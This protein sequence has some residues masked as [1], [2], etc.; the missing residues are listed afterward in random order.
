MQPPQ[1]SPSLPRGGGPAGEAGWWRGKRAVASVTIQR[2]TAS[3]SSRR[4][5]AGIRR[6]SIPA[7]R[8]HLS[9]ASSRCG[10]FPY[11]CASPSTSMAKRA[12]LQK[13]RPAGMLAPKLEPLRTLPKRMPKDHFGQ[14]HLAAKLART[15]GRPGT[16]FWRDVLEHPL[17]RASHGPPPR[18]KLG[19][20]Y[21]ASASNFRALASSSRISATRA[22]TPS[23]FRSSRM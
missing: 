22:S 10:R 3:G 18:D 13:K 16:R 11:E 14:G 12:S 2:S 8:S 15:P 9:R 20:D 1:S 6:V 17:H 19:E 21:Q 5:T 7:D 23:N 4:S